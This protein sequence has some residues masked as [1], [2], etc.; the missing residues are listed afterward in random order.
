MSDIP[1]GF[2]LGRE[3]CS[4]CGKTIFWNDDMPE[5]RPYLC[6]FCGLGLPEKTRVIEYEDF[7]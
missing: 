3:L 5:S 1:I 4:G 2:R 6:P 7:D